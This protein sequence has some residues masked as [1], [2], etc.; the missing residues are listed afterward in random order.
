MKRTAIIQGSRRNFYFNIPV[1]IAEKMKIEKG[2]TILIE[3]IDED[4][5]QI[6]FIEQ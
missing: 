4:T 1:K 3:V 6:K 2:E 5:M